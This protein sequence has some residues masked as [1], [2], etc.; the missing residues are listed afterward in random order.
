ML[1]C[2]SGVSSINNRCLRAYV[3]LLYIF[4]DSRG[5]ALI[6][7]TCKL[8]LPKKKGRKKTLIVASIL[9]YIRTTEE[10]RGVVFVL[11]SFFFFIFL[12]SV[13][14]GARSF[15]TRI[16]NMIFHVVHIY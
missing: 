7:L 14:R 6:I 4:P 11:L 13:S 1:V 9:I 16:V 3:S 12:E 5:I 8:I 2:A 10:Y 15:S